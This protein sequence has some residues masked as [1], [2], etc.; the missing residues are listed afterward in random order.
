MSYS[1]EFWQG[2][3]VGIAIC[4]MLSAAMRGENQQRRAAMTKKRPQEHDERSS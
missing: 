4:L 1:E 3:I 2:V